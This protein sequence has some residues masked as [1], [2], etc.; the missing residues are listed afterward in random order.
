MKFNKIQGDL[1]PNNGI[2]QNQK[3]KILG[4]EFHIPTSAIKFVEKYSYLKL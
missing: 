1:R 3:S 2:N 4:S